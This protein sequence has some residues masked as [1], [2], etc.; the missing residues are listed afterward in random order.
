MTLYVMMKSIPKIPHI[1]NHD[2]FF[3]S[4]R[5]K[6]LNVCMLFTKA[7]NAREILGPKICRG[8]LHIYMQI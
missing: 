6:T 3:F 4:R 8:I 2:F 1:S 5:A 7:G